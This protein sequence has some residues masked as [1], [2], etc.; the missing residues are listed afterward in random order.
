MSISRSL[1]LRLLLDGVIALGPGKAALL[2]GIQDSGSISAAARSMS[3][4]YRRAWLLVED[5]NRCFRQPLVETSTGGARGG[6]ARLTESGRDV[7]ARYAAMEQA[8]L[9]ATRADM[10]YL[11]ALLADSPA[12]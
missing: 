6:G 2:R 12:G 10:D 1:Q 9:A 3:M 8:A 11:A 4:S 7:L 5:M